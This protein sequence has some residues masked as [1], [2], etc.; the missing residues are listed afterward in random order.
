MELTL[1]WEVNKLFCLFDVVHR[2]WYNDSNEVK[3]GLMASEIPQLKAVVS[4]SFRAT[5]NNVT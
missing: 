3:L 1:V 4:K 5:N 2:D